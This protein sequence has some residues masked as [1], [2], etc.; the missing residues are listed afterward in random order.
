MPSTIT[1]NSSIYTCFFSQKP[2]LVLNLPS[3]TYFLDT[4]G[5]A[6]HFVVMVE[7]MLTFAMT[8]L[9]TD[10]TLNQQDQILSDLKQFSIPRPNSSPALSMDRPM[11]ISLEDRYN[12][13]KSCHHH[14][15]LKTYPESYTQYHYHAYRTLWPLTDTFSWSTVCFLSTNPS[16]ICKELTEFIHVDIDTFILNCAQRNKNR[17]SWFLR[18][19]YDSRLENHP[20][21]LTRVSSNS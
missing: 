7:F 18:D 8:F 15:F 21:C 9:V 10:L 11:M 17:N 5:C 20:S 1:F 13:N 3:I 2:N 6:L 16:D 14:L 19:H 12:S 4:M